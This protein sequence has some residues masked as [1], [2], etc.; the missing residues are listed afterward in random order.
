M[1]KKNPPDLPEKSPKTSLVEMFRNKDPEDDGEQVYPGGRPQAPI[2]WDRVE[3]YMEMGG[4]LTMCAYAGGVS[5]RTLERRIIER[6]GVGFKEV[7]QAAMTDRKAIALKALMNLVVKGN[8]RA[9][10]FINKAWN[11][12]SD[13]PKSMGDDD[14]NEDGSTFKIAFDPHQPPPV[15]AEFEPLGDE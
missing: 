5:P 1:A 11:N 9:T 6:Y 3:A 14:E 4:D 10:I 12:M 2:N 13:R 7:R 8:A 15:D